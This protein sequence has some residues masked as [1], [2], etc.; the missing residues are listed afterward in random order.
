MKKP[1]IY[2]ETRKKFNLDEINLKQLDKIKGKTISLA[3]TVQY[4]DLIPKIKKYLESK[5]K[6]VILKQG[7]I[8]KAHILGCNIS[9]FDK[10]ADTLLLLADGK[11]HALNNALLIQKPITIFNTQDIE[12]VT[13]KDIDK[14]NKKTK[15]KIQKFLLSD[16]VGVLVSTKPGQ[17]TKINN[18]IKQLK[19][20]SK[21]PYIFESNNIDINDFE[22]YPLTIYINTACPGL[23]LDSEKVINLA[24]IQEFL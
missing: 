9:A 22:N 3:A 14:Y 1:I 19:N 17:N 20:K 12:E 21:T 11:F 13:Q 2:I 15:A 7:A 18:L 16:K 5:N 8:H 23:E 6:K 4:L 24:H 10:S